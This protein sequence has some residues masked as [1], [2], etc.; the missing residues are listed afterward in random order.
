MKNVRIA[1]LRGKRTQTQVAADLGVPRTTYAMVENGERF[2]RRDLQAKLANYF[3]VSVDYL[4]F[5]DA[6]GEERDRA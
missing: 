4:F 3:G 5:A 1:R 6:R 2:P